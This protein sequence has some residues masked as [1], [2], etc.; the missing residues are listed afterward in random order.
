MEVTVNYP[1][2]TPDFPRSD[3]YIQFYRRIA[4]EVKRRGMTLF[5]KV[6]AAFVDPAV[7]SGVVDY[8]GITF[9]IFREGKRQQIETVLREMQPDFL[10]ISMEPHTVVANTGLT[11]LREPGR[12][13]DL[14]SLLLDGLDG[15]ETL[16]GAGAGTWEDPEFIEQLSENTNRDYI[17]LHIYPLGT[18]FTDFLQ[19]AIDYADIANRNGKMVVL[20]ETWLFKSSEKELTSG[21]SEAAINTDIFRRDVYSFWEPLDQKFIEMLTKLGHYK[22]FEF[23]SLFWS[24]YLFGYLD[25][26]KTDTS[27]DTNALLGL[28]NQAAVENLIAGEFSGTGQAY[29]DIIDS[30]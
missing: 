19:R 24:R 2:L 6:E 8:S 29:K 10:T 12:T 30:N 16:I 4:Q 21:G 28:A 7:G 25:I 3:E 18:P 23:V 17:D 20:G 14:V 13:T 9:D 22:Q 5:A 1:L 15:G 26:A 27:L 11:E